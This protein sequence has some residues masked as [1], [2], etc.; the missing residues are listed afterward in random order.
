MV[1]LVVED[2][3]RSLAFYRRLG[4][5]IA[6]DDDDRPHV[7]VK[8]E[9]GVTLFWDTSFAKIYDPDREQAVGGYR[10]LL[11]FFE[12]SREEVDATYAE[13]TGYGYRSHRAPFET[14]FGAY[15]TMLDDPD[16]NTIV[17][18][19]EQGGT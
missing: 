19:A 1:G 5:D 13:M 11:E 17:I 15:M 2:M 10:I 9:N 3:G 6:P 8:M 4:L 16:G 18:T 7:E 14:A 12:T